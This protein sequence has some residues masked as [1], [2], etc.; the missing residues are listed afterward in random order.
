MTAKTIENITNDMM[1]IIAKRVTYGLKRNAHL[2]IA[3]FAK[4]G[5]KNP[6]FQTKITQNN[7][8]F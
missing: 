7:P 5:Q 3:S 8:A 2:E 1:P 6:S 4:I